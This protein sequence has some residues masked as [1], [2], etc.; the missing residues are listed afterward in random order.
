MSAK[1]VPSSSSQK[2]GSGNTKQIP[3]ARKWCFTFNNYNEIDIISLSSKFKEMGAKYLFEKEVGEQGTPHL[4]GFVIFEDKLRP[5][6]LFHNSIHWEKCKGS[7]EDNI[8]Y[9]SKEA[10]NAND[11]SLM[12]SNFYEIPKKLKCLEAT[13]LRI[14]QC[15]I[16]KVIRNEPSD[17]DIWWFWSKMGNTGKSTFC[18]YLAIK[19]EALIISGSNKDMKCVIVEHHELTKKWPKLI[20]LD[21]PRV[22]DNDYFSYSGLEEIKNGLFC[23]SKFKGS[24]ALFNPPH[25][26]VFSNAEPCYEKMSADRW[27]VCNVDIKPEAGLRPSPLSNKTPTYA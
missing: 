26:I 20:V 1:V 16:L 6:M 4:Q 12:F 21:I 15:E 18:R 23:S 22:F 24:M 11:D 9:C 3:P 8:R 19:Y 2:S 10:R 7:E 17:R 5:K 25:I 27:K 13:K 14:W